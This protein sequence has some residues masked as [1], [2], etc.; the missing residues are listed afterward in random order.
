MNSSDH[1]QKKNTMKKAK[2]EI[3]GDKKDHTPPNEDQKLNPGLS[4]LEP[5]ALLPNTET[6]KEPIQE[7][8]TL[9]FTQLPL[10]IFTAILVLL[11]PFK[12]VMPQL[13]LH[14]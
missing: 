13:S 5:T 6:S 4:Q 11:R 7:D 2:L 12:G 8:G 10:I 9:L 1:T 14:R 3:E